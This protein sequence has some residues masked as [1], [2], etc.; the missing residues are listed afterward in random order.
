MATKADDRFL[1]EV[2][3]D[4]PIFVL[5]AKDKLAPIVVR[6]WAEL[7]AAHGCPEDRLEEAFRTQLDMRDW[8][9]RNGSK[10]PD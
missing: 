7:A 10:W 4:E 1:E 5:R 8:A 3:P 6:V 9:L 2:A